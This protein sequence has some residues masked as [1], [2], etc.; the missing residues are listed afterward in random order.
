MAAQGLEESFTDL[1]ISFVEELRFIFE[2]NARLQ[3]AAAFL[4]SAK[5][6]KR[7]ISGEFWKGI[8]PYL[9]RVF[10]KDEGLFLSGEFR[11]NVA[12]SA[13][14]DEVGKA[15]GMLPEQTKEAIWEYLHMMSGMA[16]GIHGLDDASRESILGLTSE[17]ARDL[18]S[19]VPEALQAVVDASLKNGLPARTRPASP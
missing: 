17:T 13:V 10:R 7:P 19:L 12:L 5:H 14:A 6:T 15:W 18:G 16:M 9:E 8:Q 2:G 1:V 11:N 3:M 4:Q